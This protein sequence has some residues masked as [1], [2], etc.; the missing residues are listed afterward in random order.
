MR[1]CFESEMRSY[2]RGE[3]QMLI[4]DWYTFHVSTQFIQ[5]AQEH[6]MVCLCLSAHCTNLLHPLDVEVFD[7]L[8]QSYKM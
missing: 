2:F 8:K 7:P 5:F 1:N 3:Y 4:F 6:K